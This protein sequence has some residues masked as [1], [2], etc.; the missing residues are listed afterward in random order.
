VVLLL[1]VVLVLVVSIVLVVALVLVL[2][3]VMLKVLVV[4][5]VLVLPALVLVVLLVF[6][7]YTSVT[8][9][10][11]CLVSGFCFALLCAAVL[12]V[13]ELYIKALDVGICLP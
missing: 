11:N 6:L 7:N 3:L 12:V 1:A 2:V 13:Y 9:T 4:A 10:R 5:V 8:L